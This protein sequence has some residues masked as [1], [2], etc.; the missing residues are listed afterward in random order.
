MKYQIICTDT[1]LSPVVQKNIIER[2]GKVEKLL[3]RS[4][5]FDCRIVVKFRNNKSKVEI[6]IPTPYLLLR[7]EV[8]SEELMDAVEVARNKLI[9][10][11]GKVKARLDR[12]K[13]KVNLGK[14]FGEPITIE[15]KEEIIVKEKNIYPQPMSL[16]DAI[17][18]MD[19][20]DHDFFIFEK[21]DD[22][23]I[24]VVYRRKEGGYGVINIK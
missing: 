2:L 19:S 7:S 12:S 13:N 20:L 10:Q 1:K 6:T 24:A 3:H 11:I 23:K 22:Q 8:E 14:T 17:M 9:S 18:Q 4:E 16:E 15:T 5:E 21:I